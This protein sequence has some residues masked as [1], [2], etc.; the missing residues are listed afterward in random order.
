MTARGW[1]ST[2]SGLAS[3]ARLADTLP[4][5]LVPTLILHPTAD[6]EIRMRQALEIRDAAGSDDVTYETLAGA[7]HYLE[8]HRPVAMERVASWLAARYS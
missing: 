5:V 8:G 1:L 7:P 4:S 6:T 3:H 2:W